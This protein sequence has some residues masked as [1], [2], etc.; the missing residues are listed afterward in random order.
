VS[1]NSVTNVTLGS[2][3]PGTLVQSGWSGSGGGK[4]KYYAPTPE[5]KQILRLAQRRQ[6]PDI[7]SIADPYTGLI[8]Y[9]TT[10][11]IFGGTSAACPFVAA[12]VLLAN[13]ARIARRKPVLTRFQ[14]LRTIYSSDVYSARKIY[15]VTTGVAGS[16]VAKPSY[17]LVT[18]MGTPMYGF[19]AALV[20]L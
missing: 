7:S 5:Q 11:Q 15:D 16:N 4:S 9:N 1:V 10:Y 3:T 14:V 6:S 20:A 18:G 2:N 12:I 19:Y 8:I 13:T 17:D